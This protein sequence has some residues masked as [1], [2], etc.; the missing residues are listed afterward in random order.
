LSPDGR[1]VVFDSRKS[2]R[3]AIWLVGVEDGRPPRLLTTGQEDMTPNWSHD[4]QWV[5][6]SSK[7][8]GSEQIWKMRVQEGQ[9]SEAKRLTTRQGGVGPVESADRKW[10]Y[11]FAFAV[12]A[13]PPALWKV[14]VEGG[15][16][17]RVLELPKGHH[18]ASW[19]LAKQGIY[20]VD[21]D[22]PRGP[23]I[24]FFDFASQEKK[25][26]AQFEKDPAEQLLFWFAV[27]PDGQ[28][29]LYSRESFPRDIMLVEDFR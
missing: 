11:Y 20:F 7:R 25:P 3:S 17:E 24:Q 5:Y 29:I 14:P 21:S 18:W 19:S 6:F 9:Q 27:S 10:V 13:E 22:A 28:W 23:T 2:G 16:E 12:P 15:E 1:D 8:T 26:V 4:K